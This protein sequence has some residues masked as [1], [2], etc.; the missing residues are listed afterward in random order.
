MTVI[1]HI[2]R[3]PNLP[4]RWKSVVPEVSDPSSTHTEKRG[5]IR[6]SFEL[7]K[8]VLVA[9]VGLLM[10]PVLLAVAVVVALIVPLFLIIF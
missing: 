8:I 9:I 5:L 2:L 7:V 1:T 10:L 3:C 4:E 6:I